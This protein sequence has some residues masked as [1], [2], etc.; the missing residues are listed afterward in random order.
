MALD[1]GDPETAQALVSE[2]LAIGGTAI[3]NR[4]SPTRSRSRQG[5]PP[6]TDSRRSPSGCT[7]A[8]RCSGSAWAGINSTSDGPTSTTNLDDLHRCAGEAMFEEQWE[9]GRAM[10]LLEAVDQAGGE[11]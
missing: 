10:T 3:P 6:R 1:A 8:Q 2:A 7:P 5:S 11:R 4:D 9:R